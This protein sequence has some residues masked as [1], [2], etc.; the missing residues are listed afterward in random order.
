VV[1]Y[2]E[3]IPILELR[4]EYPV[5]RLTHTVMSAFGATVEL[6]DV[7]S[8]WSGRFERPD[9]YQPEE[10]NDMRL[11][12]KLGLMTQTCLDALDWE[13]IKAS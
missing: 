1:Q 6:E 11:A 7:L 12:L 2:L 3:D 9:V 13:R 10:A 4:R 8:P 5:A